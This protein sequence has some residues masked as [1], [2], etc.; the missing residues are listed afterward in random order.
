VFADAVERAG[1]LHPENLIPAL[2]KTDR[3]GAMGR[4]RFHK[5][6]QVI[7]G[8][9]PHEEALACV[10]QWTKQGKRKIVFPASIAEGE[11]ELPGHAE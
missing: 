8:E 3:I 5:G 1:S 10:I 11:I 4:L 2:E 7:F 9:D 6:H